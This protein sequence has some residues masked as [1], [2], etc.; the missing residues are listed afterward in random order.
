MGQLV[1]IDKQNR[2]KIVHQTAKDFLLDPEV[3]SEFTVNKEEGNR[4]LAKACLPYLIG[5]EMKQ[6]RGRRSSHSQI[7][8]K[9]SPFANYAS[10]S[11]YE[12]VRL[13]DSEDDEILGLLPSEFDP[14]RPP[15]LLRVSA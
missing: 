1:W 2:V 9:R 12:H 7:Q 3:K 6:A 14:W 15:P 10:L 5:D 11:F 8:A 4:R 13:A